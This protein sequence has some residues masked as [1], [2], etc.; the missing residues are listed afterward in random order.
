MQRG[1]KEQEAEIFSGDLT[2]TMQLHPGAKNR[3]H[4]YLSCWQA[5]IVDP[6]MLLLEALA[7]TPWFAVIGGILTVTPVRDAALVLRGAT[8]G[9]KPRPAG[10]SI[11][12]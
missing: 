1:D 12:D 11:R 6:L 5:Q 8:G 2:H 4:S 7:I 10:T 3:L 9:G